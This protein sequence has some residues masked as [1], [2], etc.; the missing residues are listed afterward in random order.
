MDQPFTILAS[1]QI[2]TCAWCYPGQKII[3]VF[4]ELAGRSISHGICRAHKADMF[5]QLDSIAHLGQK[6]AI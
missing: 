4:P 1:G 6:P 3:E 2:A 5:R